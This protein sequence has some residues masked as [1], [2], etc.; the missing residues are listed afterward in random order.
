MG[1]FSLLAIIV[2]FFASQF[3]SD[4]ESRWD[5]VFCFGIIPFIL[6]QMSLPLGFGIMG[7]GSDGGDGGSGG[8]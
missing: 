4:A 7:G 8:G 3:I 2:V 1:F 5:F 6:L